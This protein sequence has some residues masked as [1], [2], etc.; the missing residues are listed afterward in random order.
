MR[1]LILMT[2]MVMCMTNEYQYGISRAAILSGIPNMACVRNALDQIDEIDR[3]DETAPPQSA[4]DMIGSSWVHG[5]RYEGE[6]FWVNMAI[7]KMTDGQIE[8]SQVRLTINK[9]P[10]DEELRKTRDI[11]LL[12]ERRL[13]SS[14]GITELGDRIHEKWFGVEKPG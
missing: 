4:L 14:C 2:I 11:M 3:I 5:F 13:S 12:V 10:S 9:M 1:T 8:F 6:G 7:S